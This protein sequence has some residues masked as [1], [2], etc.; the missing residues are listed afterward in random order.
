M[1][2]KFSFHNSN[3]HFILINCVCHSTDI[4]LV[5]L[6]RVRLSILS[7]LHLI[8]RKRYGLNFHQKDPSTH[9]LTH[10]ASLDGKTIAR[11]YSGQA[12]PF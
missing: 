1:G 9:H 12:S 7:L 5:G 8:P 3:F 11:W 10:H 4:L 2:N 6:L